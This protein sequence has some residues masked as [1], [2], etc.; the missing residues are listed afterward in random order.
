MKVL[1]FIC[2]LDTSV[3]D[4]G[5]YFGIF[6]SVVSFINYN[7]VTI[8]LEVVVFYQQNNPAMGWL[9]LLQDQL[10]QTRIQGFEDF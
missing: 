1:G 2:V 5:V 9:K 7:I 8:I 6:W 4:V 10:I 3:Y